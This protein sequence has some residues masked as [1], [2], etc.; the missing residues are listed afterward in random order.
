MRVTPCFQS[1]QMITCSILLDGMVEEIFCSFFYGHNL[2]EERK[3]LWRDIKAHQDSPLIQKS[4]WIVFGDF[5]E[6]LNGV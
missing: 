3:E 6:I 2:A 5:N 1:A 4:P